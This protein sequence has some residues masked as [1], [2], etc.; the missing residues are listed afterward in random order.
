[1]LQ[2]PGAVTGFPSMHKHLCI[3][4]FVAQRARQTA[5]VFMRVGKD[6]ASNVGDSKSGA[7]E[8]VAQSCNGFFGLRASVDDGDWIFGN[9]I[10]IDR[11]DVERRRQRDGDDLHKGK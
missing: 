10:D 3:L 9:E 6:D 5:M 7:L 8:S 11:A 4:R 1:M 2:T